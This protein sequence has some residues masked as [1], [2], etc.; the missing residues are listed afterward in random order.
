MV[1]PAIETLIC[2]LASVALS[3]ARF[4]YTVTLPDPA[5]FPVIVRGIRLPF[6]FP[7]RHWYAVEFV[8]LYC[9][10]TDS[11]QLL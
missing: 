11:E 7:H 3:L 1:S 8:V 6:Q 9:R 2:T 5:L 10:K 4:R